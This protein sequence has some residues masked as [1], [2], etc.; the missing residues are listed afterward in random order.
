MRDWAY[1]VYLH[2]TS[3]KLRSDQMRPMNEERRR[4]IREYVEQRGGI[5]ERSEEE[6][7]ALA[8]VATKDAG[9][10]GE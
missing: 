6:K 1:A 3:L 2:I 9:T 5:G 10:D 7:K 8:E 4:F